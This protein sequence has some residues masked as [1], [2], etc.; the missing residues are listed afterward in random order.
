MPERTTNKT[1]NNIRHSLA[2]LLAT[3]VLERFPNAELGIG[4]TV[5]NGFYYDFKI[6]RGF[7]S[8]DLG[9]FEKTIKRL[10]KKELSFKSKK[11]TTKEAKKLFSAGSGSAFNGNEQ[12]FK[13]ELIKDFIGDKKTLTV[14]SLGDVFI[15][16]CK[17]GHVK[18]TKNINPEAFK[19]TSIAGAYWKGD[20]KNPQLQ[21]I[22]GVAF[23]TKKE[24]S[25]HLEKLEQAKQRDHRKIGQELDLF[26]TNED[27]GPGLILW[28]PRGTTIKEEL[29]KLGK[30]TEEDWGYQ[31]ISTPHIAKEALYIK[32]GHLPYYKDDMYPAMEFENEKYYIKPMNCPFTHLI[33]NARKRSYKEL[34][35][36][37]A[38][39]GSV[40]RNEDSG[41]L[42][43]L[44]R[45]RGMT[46]NDAHIYC[47]EDQALGEVLGVMK[48]HDYYYKLLGIENYYIELA[49]PDFKARPEKYFD[50]KRAWGKAIAILRKAARSLN[51]DVIEKKGEAAFYGPKFDFK[52]ESVT[53]RE[54]GISTNQLDFGSGKRFGLTYTNN[55]GKEKTVPYIIHRAPLGS[56][57]RFIGFLIERYAGAFP[58]WLS[59][60]QTQVLAVSKKQEVYAKRVL[61]ALRDN[62]IRAQLTSGNETLGKR[63]REGEMQKIPY[64]LVVGDKEVKTNS[65][66]I[67]KRGKKDIE[68]Q[69]LTKFVEKITEEIEKRK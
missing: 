52:I 18:N 23:E 64:L 26:T 27:V 39:Y 24:L 59:P 17:G 1:I 40:Y 25:V 5:K 49:L 28:M 34:P 35:I 22:Y 4:P 30:E 69:K 8:K 44:L 43:G 58:A 42:L 55:S 45:V 63:I 57:E 61:K 47:T 19:L 38:E 21:R 3:A 60:V 50:D 53:G 31:R 56:T 15:D 62:N 41:T 2:H 7:S 65:V 54:F 10:I 48:L 36:R 6:S 16:L 68:I 32:S 29:E 67:R 33:Y 14:Y 46:Q 66:A 13:L 12:P 37:Y 9:E 11:V 51:I 20:E